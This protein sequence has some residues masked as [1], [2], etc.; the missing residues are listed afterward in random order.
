[1]IGGSKMSEK[2][3]DITP[4]R[5]LLNVNAWTKQRKIQQTSNSN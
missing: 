1:M 4:N 2:I 3:H 5:M